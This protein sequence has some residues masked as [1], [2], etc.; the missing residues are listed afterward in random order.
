M[1]LVVVVCI[2]DLLAFV[3]AISTYMVATA[4]LT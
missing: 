2:D 1:S 3:E 4:R